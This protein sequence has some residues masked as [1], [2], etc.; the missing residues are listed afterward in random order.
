VTVE[1]P[2][3]GFPVNP[4][5]KAELGDNEI[6]R[7]RKGQ[8]E[9]LGAPTTGSLPEDIEA[10]NT[11]K[12]PDIRPEATP[13][14]TME[15]RTNS[16]VP[17]PNPEEVGREEKLEPPWQ[18]QAVFETAEVRRCQIKWMVRYFIPW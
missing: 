14:P 12:E 11:A 18:L 16:L 2:H 3:E 6:F 13:E 4:P 15:L 7:D 1:Q 8:P 9:H 10:S 5:R 17:T